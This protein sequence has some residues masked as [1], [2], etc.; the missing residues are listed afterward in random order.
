MKKAILSFMLLT[1]CAAKNQFSV[2]N[3]ETTNSLC[4]D[5]LIVNMTSEGCP[6][7]VHEQA[8][9]YVKLSCQDTNLGRWTEHEYYL[10][11]TGTILENQDAQPL[12]S[13]MNISIGFSKISQYS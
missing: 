8:D 11:Q 10:F 7:I 2:S 4:L 3:F 12:C 1:G 6:N 5:A 13:D 9:S